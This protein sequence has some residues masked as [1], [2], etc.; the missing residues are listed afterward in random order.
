MGSNSLTSL[1]LV[2]LAEQI[3]RD[4]GIDWQALQRRDYD[5]GRRRPDDG[6]V[7]QLLH[8]LDCTS[9]ADEHGPRLSEGGLG[10]LVGAA[11]FVTGFLTMVGF[12]F[13]H[14]SGLVNVLWF[15]AFF[16]LL[17]FGLCLVAAITLG[18]AAF[19]NSRTQFTLNPARLV[20][21]RSIPDRRYWREF[22]TVFSLA[23]LRY[24]QGMGIG[25]MSGAMAA[26]LLVL[27]VNDFSFVWS[28]TFNLSDAFMER[29]ARLVST[30]WAGWLPA[31]TVDAGVIADS[32][33][34]PTAGRFT[35]QQVQSMHSWWPFLFAAMA[36]YALL[37]RILLWLVS[38]LLYRARLRRAFVGY[39]GADLVLRRMRAPAVSTR[40]DR[41]QPGTAGAAS[42]PPAAEPRP[43]TLL[44][45]WVDAVA[46]TEIGAYPELAGI[47]VD[48]VV[49]AGL[50]PEQD[51]RAL[52]LAG[53]AGIHHALVVARGWE[54]PLSELADFLSALRQHCSCELWLRPL[55]GSGVGASAMD[56]WRQFGDALP[57]GGIPVAVL[58]P[59]V[60]TDGEDRR[61]NT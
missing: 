9:P 44:V 50:G 18:L 37:P 25:F 55:G 13:A 53:T 51:A 27:A 14:T 58:G 36:C 7:D 2:R 8:W 39:P 38:R 61:E 56:D 54:P 11:L 24:G 29:F 32:R 43:D 49:A 22:R 6:A 17:Q 35:P 41:R 26:F 12:L 10:L 48:Q 46:G 5:I 47:P 16:V 19:G 3:E 20:F 57:G 31:A 52:A 33:Y 21:A 40:G 30:P 28:S 45:S 15:F 60:Q 4:K 23:F 34:H 42:R 1:D 59:P